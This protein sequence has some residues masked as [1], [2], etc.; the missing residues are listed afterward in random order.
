MQDIVRRE[1]P[2]SRHPTCTA[3]T[4][5]SMIAALRLM[6]QAQWPSFSRGTLL[7]PPPQWEV[8]PCHTSVGVSSARCASAQ[9]ARTRNASI[10]LQML[11][12]PTERRVHV[13]A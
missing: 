11:V 6:C 2:L 9:E 7:C 12:K 3:H 4:L 13:S 10:E 5:S 1:E 8:L